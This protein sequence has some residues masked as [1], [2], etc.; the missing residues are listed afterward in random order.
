MPAIIPTISLQC[1]IQKAIDK[2]SPAYPHLGALAWATGRAM[3]PA[4]RLSRPQRAALE[5]AV[6]AAKENHAFLN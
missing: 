2:H 6:K 3:I 1:A 4:A 5:A